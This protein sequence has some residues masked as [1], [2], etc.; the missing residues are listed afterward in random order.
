MVFDGDN[1]VIDLL[2]DTF[3]DWDEIHTFVFPDIAADDVED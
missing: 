3:R 1:Y 2:E